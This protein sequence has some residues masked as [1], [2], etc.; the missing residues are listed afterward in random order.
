M[1]VYQ[2]PLNEKIRLFMR[3]SYLIKRFNSHLADPTQVNCQAAIMVLLELYNLSSR[4]DVKNAA[5]H[6]LDI[7]TQA[8]RQV[9]GVQGVDSSQARKI[10]KKLDEKSKRLYS[11][12]G[13]LGQQLKAHNF[14]NILKQ[15]A[16][17]AGG[18]NN[19]DIPLF[20]YWLNQNE[21]E[22]VKDLRAWSRPYEIAFE[23]IEL[24]MDLIYQGKD[25]KHTVAKGGF[26]QAT[27][28]PEIDYQ[29]LSIE[30]DEGTKIYP[31]ISAGK[32]RF[33]VRFV[34]SKTLDEKGKQIIEDVAFKLT[35][36][37]F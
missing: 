23:A 13:Q 17:I 37:S 14:L 31:E 24:L 4:L 9:E 10:L 7:Q 28:R 34:D 2:Q 16:S 21:E 30:L 8:V 35:L 22:R 5:L 32:Q 11:F 20:N 19:I 25:E 6:V 29:I 12:R 33:S 27:L 3:L 15:R 1:A 18:I 36:Y 26:F